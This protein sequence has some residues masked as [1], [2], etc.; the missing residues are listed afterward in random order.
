MISTSRMTDR[1]T[2]RLTKEDTEALQ[3]VQT[4]L[5]PKFPWLN[6]A[7]LVRAALHEAAITLGRA[8][9]VG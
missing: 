3:V 8:G 9:I 5:R 6:K 1:V 7:D 2:V 4:Q